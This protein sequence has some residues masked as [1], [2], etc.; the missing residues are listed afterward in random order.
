MLARSESVDWTLVSLRELRLSPD[1]SRNHHS[2][3]RSV[4][5]EQQVELPGRL[6]LAERLTERV[7]DAAKAAE[8]LTIA[9]QVHDRRMLL[10]RRGNDD[11]QLPAGSQPR[12]AGFEVWTER[13]QLRPSQK[14]VLERRLGEPAQQRT[15]M[16]V[17]TKRMVGQ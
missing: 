2:A 16:V 6:L 1:T 10:E 3:R 9:K 11:E 4:L 12:Q 13:G 5:I 14:A 15:P 8:R 7:V 17:R